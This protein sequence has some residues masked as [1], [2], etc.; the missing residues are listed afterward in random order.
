MISHPVRV[1]RQ[2]PAVQT[3]EGTMSWSATPRILITLLM[4]TAALSVLL[5]TPTVSGAGPKREMAITFDDLPLNT[6]NFHDL[7]SQQTITEKL[8][9]CIREN[10]IPAVGFVNEGKLY[11][12][13]EPDSARVALLEMWLN[14][15]C[16]LGNHTFSH[17]SLHHTQMEEFQDNVLRGERVMKELLASRADTLRYF[18]HPCLHTGRN[19]ETKHT[20]E[21]FLEHHGYTIAP[22]TMDNSEW[23]YA[24]AYEN[25]VV[26]GDSLN[27]ARILADYV[28]YMERVISYYEQQSVALLGY[29]VKQILLLHANLLNAD[30][31]DQIAR[32]LL[33][34]EYSFI[35]LE[36]ALTDSAYTLPDTF[37]GTAGISWLH[38]W[39]HTAGKRDEF[40]HGE[41]SV[42]DYVVELAGLNR[43]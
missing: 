21:R 9:K 28:P 4:A 7:E 6:R 8:V 41:P 42:P 37:V 35:T 29:E 20:L 14:A 18:R 38:R 30:V 26:A 5:N 39:A 17:P 1:M 22:V 43:E 13:G 23:I 3:N 33:K 31:F 24:A 10:S 40:F 25:A 2:E 16:E 19:L 11:R 27:T 34:R 36:E 32:I 12:N 15:G